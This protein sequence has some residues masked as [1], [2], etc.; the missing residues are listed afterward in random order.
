MQVTPGGYI[1]SLEMV[2]T[3]QQEDGTDDVEVITVSQQ[4]GPDGEPVGP[5]VEEKQHG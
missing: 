1:L 4:F 3:R 2:V 5:A